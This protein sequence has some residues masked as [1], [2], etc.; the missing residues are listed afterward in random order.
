MEFGRDI[1]LAQFG[2]D[3]DRAHGGI[4]V[5]VA[6][7]E[8]HRGR[9]FVKREIA[10]HSRIVPFAGIGTVGSVFEDV[11]GINGRGEVYVARELVDLVDRLVRVRLACRRGHE[12]EVPAGGEAHDPDFIRVDSPFL[13][14]RTDDAHASLRVLPRGHVLRNPFAA[15]NAVFQY[16]DRNPFGIE[17]LGDL[18]PFVGVSQPHIRAA[19]ADDHER[20]GRFLFRLP[21]FV[22]RLNGVFFFSRRDSRPYVEFFGRGSGR[23]RAK[24]RRD[25]AQRDRGKGKDTFHELAPCKWFGPR[26]AV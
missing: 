3:G 26:N 17:V 23:A 20:I 21:V 4:A 6:V 16:D 11:G 10:D 14:A 1:H 12:S 8:A 18:F 2:V 5:G 7:N 24:E 13:R 19:G 9:F 22:S 15:R 25:G